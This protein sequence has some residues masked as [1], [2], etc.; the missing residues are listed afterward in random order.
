MMALLRDSPKLITIH[1]VSARYISE[2]FKIHPLGY[3]N[4]C[5]KYLGNGTKKK[6]VIPQG[7]GARTCCV[8]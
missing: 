4:I 5:T 8:G 6:N 7:G 2:T 3:M 1:D